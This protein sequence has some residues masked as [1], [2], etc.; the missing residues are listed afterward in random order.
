MARYPG[1]VWRPIPEAQSEP[2]IVPT[3]LIFHTAV[4][5]AESLF[6]YWSR[7]DVGLE[8]HFYVG[9]R[10]VEQYQDT[11]RQADANHTA[12]VRAI[13][14][15][16]WDN[17]RPETTPWTPWQMDQLVDL[18]VWACKTHLIP[19]RFCPDHDQPGIGWHSMWG[20]PSPWTPVRG[21][22]CPG[23]A[24]IDQMPILLRRVQEALVG[25]TPIPEEDDFMALFK[26]IEEFNEAVEAAAARAV[27]SRFTTTG[28]GT[29]S[30]LIN[31]LASTIAAG[32]HPLGQAV[33][34]AARDGVDGDIKVELDPED[35]AAL[36]DAIPD[37]IAQDV[38]DLLAVRLAG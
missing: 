23:R 4:S 11:E 2:R 34:K 20:A 18:A 27:D 16:T 22:T 8:S 13:S 31:L 7:S 3:Q 6:A 28:T 30:G 35:I 32:S 14:V 36:A 1:A 19:A 15:E 29:R 17:L 26:D 12:N 9:Q 33:R 38:A 10:T 5:T 37:D 25:K 21:K 24:R